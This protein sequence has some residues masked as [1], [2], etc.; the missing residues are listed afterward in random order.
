ML[1]AAPSLD[2]YKHLRR[3]TPAPASLY[4]RP[5]SA[6]ASGAVSDVIDWL[7]RAI[8]VWSLWTQLH[9]SHGESAGRASG[10]FAYG[11]S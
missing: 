10:R 6:L 3:G 9:T 4:D 8:C 2:A 5:S 7:G 11:D 1:N